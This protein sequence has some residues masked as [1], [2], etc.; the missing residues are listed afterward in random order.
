MDEKQ[1]RF[2]LSDAGHLSTPQHN[3]ILEAFGSAAVFLA[4]PANAR[5]HLGQERGEAL[6]RAVD[7]P[8]QSG[9]LSRLEGEGVRLL[10]R[11]EADY[12]PGLLE[13]EEPP[14][15]LYMKGALPALCP[16]L[17][18]I[19][20]RRP[21][22]YGRQMAE[23]FG[24][25]LGAEGF[26]IVSGL[27]RGIDTLAM[28]AARKAG[29]P[30]VGV[31]GCGI[32]RVYP[33]ENRELFASIPGD[34]AL[35]SEYPPGADPNGYHF[36]WRNR[37]IAGLGLA[38]L[39]VEATLRSGSLVTVRWALQQGKE[40]F[41]LPGP[42][43]SENSRGCHQLIRDGATLVESHSDIVEHFRHWLRASP[44]LDEEALPSGVNKLGLE[45]APRTI[46]ELEEA[47]GLSPGELAAELMKAVARG[48]AR[49]LPGQR[50]CLAEKQ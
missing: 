14:P 27:A 40:I 23:L 22:L 36:P 10:I 38:L 42:V 45:D 5:A 21:T 43:N 12:P 7:S 4:D 34:G 32:D 16:L 50:F 2:L 20:T 48:E 15:L 13:V 39:V 28:Q 17:S 11:G 29:A 24:R 25:N 41:A 37:L 30:L 9:R 3:G 33:E 19:G 18:V 47:T 6:L 31:L 1:A 26:C 35:I 44:R 46:A 49:R 8:E